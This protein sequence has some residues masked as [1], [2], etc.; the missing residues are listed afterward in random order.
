MGPT[1]AIVATFAGCCVL[2]VFV[3]RGGNMEPVTTEIEGGRLMPSGERRVEE[4]GRRLIDV[5]RHAS[6]GA[7][8]TCG[9]LFKDAESRT[10]HVGRGERQSQCRCGA[11]GAEEFFDRFHD[12]FTCLFEV[13][14]CGKKQKNEACN[15]YCNTDFKKVKRIK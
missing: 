4:D 6:E 9:G 11:G 12:C 2:G 10:F 13:T 7:A 1:A 3:R 5:A 14:V 8:Q 15:H